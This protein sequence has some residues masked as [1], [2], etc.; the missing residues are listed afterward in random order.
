M[1]DVAFRGSYDRYKLVGTTKGSITQVDGKEE[2]NLGNFDE[3]VGTSSTFSG[4]TDCGNHGPR[5]STIN[6]SCGTKFEVTRSTEPNTCDYH[7]YATLPCCA[8]DD[9]TA[10][11]P[12]AAPA[13]I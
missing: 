6:W 8:V 12:D 2:Y 3:I 1:T 13:G 7:F 5:K 11:D 4:G 10:W 9:P